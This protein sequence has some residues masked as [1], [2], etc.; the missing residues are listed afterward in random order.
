[1]VTA[2]GGVT[3]PSNGEL[4]D[5]QQGTLLPAQALEHLKPSMGSAAAR[6]AIL[7]RLMNGLIEG[8]A[9]DTAKWLGGKKVEEGT[10][11][12]LPSSLWQHL[13]VESE[14][15]L[16]ITND[17]AFHIEAR[18]YGHPNTTIYAFSVRFKAADI[19]KMTP[20]TREP[21]AALSVPP[22]PP[23]VPRGGAPGKDF[24]E[25]M[26]IEIFRRSYLDNYQ[27]QSQADVV[28]AMLDWASE[29]GHEASDS[30]VKTRAR[31]VWPVIK[32]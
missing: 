28:R 1:M 30:A 2:G 21:L 22:T 12:G 27:P 7:Q 3:K 6:S 5:F 18:K 29:Q 10:F 26:I 9:E 17:A 8:Y 11:V 13:A 31:K 24:W 15:A 4:G 25:D 20:P 23:A 32:P 19:E 16:W 14:T